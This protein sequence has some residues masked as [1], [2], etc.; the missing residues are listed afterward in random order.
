MNWHPPR[1]R[2]SNRPDNSRPR[3]RLRQKGVA[4][5]DGFE[6]PISAV[7]TQTLPAHHERGDPTTTLQ[8]LSIWHQGNDSNAPF[9]VQS[10]VSYQLDDPDADWMWRPR[11]ESNP[12][13]SAG[14][15][16]P[17]TPRARGP[18]RVD[19]RAFLR[20]IGLPCLFGFQGAEDRDKRKRARR[21]PG[22]FVVF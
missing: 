1:I 17:R 21:W 8:Q 18:Q 3:Y 6:P 13:T 14:Q 12:P 5:E 2:T 10:H 9:M 16:T 7:S 15:E 22:P 11:R 19:A 4:L 20:M